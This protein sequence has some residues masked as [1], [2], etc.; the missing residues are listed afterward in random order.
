M[1][2]ILYG[3]KQVL[4]TL[5]ECLRDFE[6]EMQCSI[7]L[8]VCKDPISLP[9][10]HFYC[11]NCLDKYCKQPGSGDDNCPM[12]KMK[13]KRRETKRDEV[14]LSLTCATRT[15][16]DLLTE[17]LD[18]PP[19]SQDPSSMMIA[20]Y[21]FRTPLRPVRR[22]VQ[23][24]AESSSSG[25]PAPKKGIA[26]QVRTR[27][28]PARN[29]KSKFS[30]QAAVNEEGEAEGCEMSS[31]Q[32]SKAVVTTLSQDSKA[33]DVSSEEPGGGKMN[34]YLAKVKI[35]R[36]DI[37]KLTGKRSRG[38]NSGKLEWLEQKLVEAKKM[39]KASAPPIRAEKPPTKKTPAPKKR[40]NKS[41][42]PP[43]KTASP[44]RRKIRNDG[45]LTR[46]AGSKRKQ[47]TEEYESLYFGNDGGD[48]YA[49]ANM[50]ESDKNSSSHSRDLPVSIGSS[51]PFWDGS[52]PFPARGISTRSGTSKKSTTKQEIIS[53]DYVRDR[54][55][56]KNRKSSHYC[57]VTTE[58]WGCPQ[59]TFI[60]KALETECSICEFDRTA[61]ANNCK[62]RTSLLPA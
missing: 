7:C 58:A 30:R 61:I 5:K 6:R 62:S 9:C 1:L 47:A 15:L 12:C 40:K 23:N 4:D 44:H 56:R 34:E 54:P 33:S 38:A 46:S 43:P 52:T 50:I 2:D 51:I 42:C 37:F 45:L 53:G 26:T 59:C 14:L 19:L 36:E 10:S 39:K 8:S 31:S 16:H 29:R 35:L 48:I 32:E 60:N 21:A 28:L 20:S 11:T 18:L 49:L 57:M 27:M 55:K 17:D 13:F 24:A 25:T 41:R 22:N 3:I